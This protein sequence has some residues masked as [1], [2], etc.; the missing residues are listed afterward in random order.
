MIGRT[1]EPPSKPIGSVNGRKATRATYAPWQQAL[2]TYLLSAN[3]VV[4][5]NPR[6]DGMIGTTLR[7]VDQGRLLASPT[8]ITSTRHE[9]RPVSVPPG[10][11]TKSGDRPQAPA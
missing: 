5:L 6:A 4:V 10:M 7:A 1:Y 3:V 2:Q 9:F 11:R 8:F